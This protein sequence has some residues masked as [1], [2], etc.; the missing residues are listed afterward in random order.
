MNKIL[1]ICTSPDKG[2]LE[3]YFVKLTQYYHSY[4][5][6]VLPVCKKNSEIEK[7]VSPEAF[8]VN[9]INLFNIFFYAK[10]LAKI[11]D[12][13]GIKVIHVSWTKDILLA[14]LTKKLCKSK[15]TLIYYRQMKITRMKNDFY[16]RFL[17]QN[18]DLILVITDKLMA[19][20]KKFFPVPGMRIKKL[21]YGIQKLIPELNQKTKFFENN[22]L[23]PD[24]LTLGI[25]SRIEDQKG[26]HLVIEAMKKIKSNIQLIM[27]GHIMNNDYKEILDKLINKFDLSN[28]VKFIPHS[29]Q[30]MALMPFCDLI[31]LPTYEET[32][33][34]VVAEAMIMGVPVIGSNAGGV[35]EIIEDGHNGLL[36]KSKDSDNLAEKILMLVNDKELRRKLAQNAKV[37]AEETYDYQNHFNLL[38]DYI[39]NLRAEYE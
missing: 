6:S 37:Y 26:Q 25:F 11:V 36:F 8:L 35:P 38:D 12:Q 19:E 22:S 13:N 1:A 14:V 7:L 31:I 30:A 34:L 18:L 20:A 32:F 28:S 3:L 21:T 9:K 23:N 5:Q 17:Y 24:L 39:K 16:H 29:N 4:H 2:G 15:V 33:G 27:V 10:K